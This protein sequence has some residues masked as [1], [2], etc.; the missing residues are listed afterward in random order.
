MVF[1]I[2]ILE[3]HPRAD[4]TT[5]NALVAAAGKRADEAVGE[6]VGAND[7]ADECNEAG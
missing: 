2:W 4:H 1:Q 6:T 7:G 5:E 3:D